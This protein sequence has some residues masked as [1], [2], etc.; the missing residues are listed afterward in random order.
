MFDFLKDN[1]QNIVLVVGAVAILFWPQVSAA[2][3]GARGKD[4]TPS[5]EP[6]NQPSKC[7]CCCPEEPYHDDAPK[8]DWV[9]RTMEIRAYCLDHRLTDGVD[10]CEKLVSV[11]VASKPDKPE[12]AIVMVKKETR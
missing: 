11:L 8:S 3:K 5:T 4:E 10:L 2:I 9:V 12:K 6:S 7:N 1:L